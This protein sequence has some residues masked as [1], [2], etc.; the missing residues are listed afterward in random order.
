MASVYYKYP[1]LRNDRLLKQID[2]TRTQTT[3]IRVTLLDWQENEMEYIE[4]EITGG[5]LNIDGSSAVRR[6]G[7]IS[8]VATNAENNYNDLSFKYSLNKKIKIAFGLDNIIAPEEYP[9]KDFPIF[10]FPQGVFFITGC[11]FSHSSAG[12]TVDIKFTDKMALLNGVVGGILPASVEFDKMETYDEDAKQVIIETPTMYQNIKE[13]VNHWGNE[14]LGKILIGDLPNITR[15]VVTFDQS[16][17]N[18]GTVNALTVRTSNPNP[19]D[20]TNPWK[21]DNFLWI[22][23]NELSDNKDL[24][25]PSVCAATLSNAQQYG[26]GAP[27]DTWKRYSQGCAIG[28]QYTTFTYPG[29]LTATAGT[30]LTTILDKI[31]EALGNYEYF[32]DIDGNFR[33][34]EIKNYL[35]TSQSS[36]I[37][38]QLDQDTRK[39]KTNIGQITDTT[40]YY[41]D[42]ATGKKQNFAIDRT[43]G[44]KGE[45]AYDFSN[46]PL[47]I[48]YSNNPNY[49]NIKN[50][51]IVWGERKTADGTKYPIRYHV[52]IDEKPRLTNTYVYS[53]IELPSYIKPV[54][55][56]DGENDY[57]LEASNA[58][59]ENYENLY[60]SALYKLTGRK[61]VYGRF[62]VDCSLATGA[63]P[64]GTEDQ[65]ILKQYDKDGN[66]LSITR[67][68]GI[69]LEN[70]ETAPQGK[71]Y[72]K[73]QICFASEKTA[74]RQ[75]SPCSLIDDIS[76]INSQD[77][78]ILFETQW[79]PTNKTYYH[80]DLNFT[81]NGGGGKASRLPKGFVRNANPV[82]VYAS[83]ILFDLEQNRPNYTFNFSP[84]WQSYN[85]SFFITDIPL[86]NEQVAERKPSSYGVVPSGQIYAPAEDWRTELLAQGY[87]AEKNGTD[88]GYYFPELS[89]EWPKIYDICHN[90][91][92]DLYQDHDTNNPSMVD[93]ENGSYLITAPEPLDYFLDFIDVSSDIGKYSVNNI[94]RRTQVLV[95]NSINCIFEPP[96]PDLIFL[97]TSRLSGWPLANQITTKIGESS[98][99]IANKCGIINTSTDMGANMPMA[100]YVDIS[101]W[102]KAT[103]PGEPE[104]QPQIVSLPFPVIVYYESPNPS[105]SG[106]VSV[107]FQASGIFQWNRYIPPNENEQWQGETSTRESIWDSIFQCFM[108]NNPINN[109]KYPVEYRGVVF[110]D[111]FDPE[112]PNSKDAKAQLE[113]RYYQVLCRICKAL[114]SVEHQWDGDDQ[115]QNEYMYINSGVNSGTP[116]QVTIALREAFQE[117]LKAQKQV[118]DDLV[119]AY[120]RKDHYTIIDNSHTSIST[121][122][123]PNGADVAMKD[124]LYQYTNYKETISL[125]TIPIYHLEPNTLIKV[126]DYATGMNDTYVINSMSVS[127]NTGST[128]TINATKAMTKI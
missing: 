84:L 58:Q 67:I 2:E 20:V 22:D 123:A 36:E 62:A 13:I 72:N 61:D 9:I 105:L 82:D 38:S 114:Q 95:D 120:Q 101:P 54:T 63:S 113:I 21:R 14:Q 125:T 74:E 7:S 122:N 109:S 98:E 46:S 75:E 10:W 128:M 79:K 70:D 17:L 89:V 8:F 31:K 56:S 18:I 27:T 118:A 6:T 33:F 104:R 44:G 69:I 48:S 73:Y 126:R 39:N 32:Y 24:Y 68:Y 121:A 127:F 25:V 91:F 119:E 86:T 117:M 3:Y 77:V 124:L 30:A 23:L 51:F 49:D 52:A 97:S 65:H 103:S 111:P 28:Y 19:T 81:Q 50:D 59:I 64:V 1:Y 42:V 115:G 87:L 112:D 94:G 16:Y 80:C 102:K 83:N 15:K 60:G 93:E 99:T 108:A 53:N 37:L 107:T 47:I 57:K 90:H 66:L 4:G 88:P 40:Y 34:Q 11:S 71:A 12:V 96:T 110:S 78:C 76:V 85:F 116:M 43:K 35:N 55:N 45:I 26:G 41:L 92:Y 106:G 5:N 100:L 29:E